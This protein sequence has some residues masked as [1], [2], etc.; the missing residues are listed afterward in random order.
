[1][2]NKIQ[3]C[4]KHNLWICETDKCHWVCALFHCF[5]SFRKYGTFVWELPNGNSQNEILFFSKAHQS[6][7]RSGLVFLK[8]VLCVLMQGSATQNLFLFAQS[9]EKNLLSELCSLCCLLCSHAFFYRPARITICWN[10]LQKRRRPDQ[11]IKDTRDKHY[12][13]LLVFFGIPFILT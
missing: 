10:P 3:P 4:S 7:P 2:W 9:L 5:K 1:M 12:L 6:Y 8:W 13:L 11:Q